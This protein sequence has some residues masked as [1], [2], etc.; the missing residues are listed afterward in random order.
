MNETNIAWTKHTWNAISG[1]SK[2]S[3][4]CKFCYA[5][6]LSQK[7]GW[8]SKPW[9]LQNEDE[10]VKM[11]PHKLHEPYKLPKEAARVF[12]NSMSDMFHRAI[13]NWY[14]AAMF[15]VMLDTPHLTYQILTK[16]PERAIDWDVR[17]LAAIQSDEFKAFRELVKD[18]RV[19]DALSRN[20]ESAWG[21]NIWMGTSVEDGRVLHRIE[22]LRQSK[23]KTRFISA[24]PLLGAW[25]NVDLTGI[26]WVIV[27][28]ESGQHMTA[29][30]DRWMKMEWAR[31]IRDL[32]VA[33]DVAYFFKQDSGYRTELRPYLIEEDG[34][35]WQWYQYPDDRAPAKNIDTGE[36][37]HMPKQIGRAHV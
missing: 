34:S 32:C 2:V 23:A 26:H 33:Q 11:K 10:N 12:T 15:C 4:G 5:A 20:W 31:E 28:G 18:K 30:P 37:K 7:Y 13:P 27:G 1:C 16:R 29:N 8:T 25:G 6:T 9:T 22:S 19:K 17:F 14:I 36:L 21:D 24:E 35:K 3:D